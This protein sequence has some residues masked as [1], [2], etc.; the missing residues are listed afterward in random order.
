MRLPAL[1]VRWLAWSAGIVLIVAA[2]CLL[3]YLPW[4]N[5]AAAL[6][7]RLAAQR[8]DAARLRAE[9]QRVPALQDKIAA[10][11]IALAAYDARMPSAREIPSLLVQLAELARRTG[12]TLTSLRPGT[13]EPVTAPA[14]VSVEPRRPGADGS[15]ARGLARPVGAAR[16]T[17]QTQPTGYQRVLI[18][19]DAKGTL[20]ATSDF[21]ETLQDLPG[22]VVLLDIRMT[23][24]AT[25]TGQNPSDP[26]LTLAVTATAYVQ[27]GA[28][29]AP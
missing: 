28:E 6:S 16:S 29:P 4:T 15:A 24:P 13:L 12:V 22:F 8:A 9:A 7:A 26:V 17:A 19:F 23:M 25:E 27:P 3:V 1:P 18:E 14:A 20:L 5:E 21:L 2:F 11:L 10:L